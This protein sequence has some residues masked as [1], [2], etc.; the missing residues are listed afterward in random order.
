LQEYLTEVLHAVHG[1]LTGIQYNLE[2]DRLKAVA[3][4]TTSYSTGQ[5]VTWV[6]GSHISEW[7]RPQRK[8]HRTVLTV[9]HV[10]ASSA[11]PL[12]F[13]AI[14]LGDAWYGD[15]GL[16]LAAPLSPAL[17]LGARRI[18]A[19]STR[20][21]RSAE[22][23]E[24]HSTLGYPPPAQVA[25]VLLNSIFLDLLDHDALRLEQVN[26]LLADLPRDKWE[27]LEPVRL[28]T[29]RPSCDLG[30]LA[31]EHEARLPRGFRFL[32]RGLGTKH[33]RSPDFLSLVLFQPDYL[34]TLIEVGEADAMAQA[35][36]ISEFLNENI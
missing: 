15:G 22:E 10:M 30:N 24:E 31:N 5:S 34:R 17:H 35:D 1:E 29:L 16:R 25:G 23:A 13:P 4:T 36:K 20:Y 8:A 9:D 14:Q 33:T 7:E 12:F 19:I 27:N 11:L 6:Q 2:R 28:L 18:I 21:D 32:T 26:R 3:L